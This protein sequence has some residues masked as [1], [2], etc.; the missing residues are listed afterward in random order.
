MLWGVF[1]ALTLDLR[2]FSI[3][4]MP[5][6]SEFWL[7]YAPLLFTYGIIRFSHYVAHLLFHSF[8]YTIKTDIMTNWMWWPPAL[9]DQ[10]ETLLMIFAIIFQY[11]DRVKRIWYLSPMRA[12]K[13]QASLHIRAVSPEPSLL[14]HTSSESRGIFRQKARSLDPLNG[15]ACTV[16]ICHDGMLEDTNSL[17][18]AHMIMI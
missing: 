5:C 12:A 3:S 15:W 8:Q 10:F 16:K 18:G 2:W 11:M 13:V 6:T 4:F 14:T 17:E 9:N 1:R 7:I